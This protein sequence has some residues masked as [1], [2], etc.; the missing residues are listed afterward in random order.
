MRRQYEAPTVGASESVTEFVRGCPR[1]EMASTSTIRYRLPSVKLRKRQVPLLFLAALA[2]GAVAAAT[3]YHHRAKRAVAEYQ[4]QLLAE[5]EI[6]SV[7]QLIPKPV[8]PDQDGANLFFQAIAQLNA[9]RGVLDTNPPSGMTMVA[10][11][12]ARVGCTQPDIRSKDATNNWDEAIR[13][14]TASADSLALLEELI[15]RPNLDFK[16][17]YR[18]GFSAPLPNLAQTKR[19]AQR[20]YY[21]ALCD[22]HRGDAASATTRLRALLA[23][24]QGSADERLVISQLVRI[25]VTA[26][27]V[28]GTWELLQSPDV[29]D[30][31]LALIQYDWRR[32]EFNLSAENALAMERAM[33]QMTVE[34][35]RNSS[36]EFRQVASAYSW[37][38]AGGAPVSGD[39]LSRVGKF[40]KEAWNK[41]RLTAKEA[42]WRYSWAY[43]D[44]LR[45]LKGLQVLIEGT[46]QARTNGDFGAAL[47]D[48]ESKLQKLGFQNLE[49]NDMLPLFG[50]DVD[51]RTLFSQGVLS[52]NHYLKKVMAIET[53]R[54]LVVTATALQRYKLRHGSYPTDLAALV[55]DLLPTLPRDPADGDVLHYRANSDGN[56]LL[57]SVGGDF[58]DNGGDPQ[59][60][61]TSPASFYWQR[62]RD[63]V[64][65]QPATQKEVEDF[66]QR[67]FK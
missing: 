47:R 25:A 41:S 53:S 58:A 49:R 4:Q 6:L 44:Q 9:G 3:V 8:P 34:Q 66:Y 59:P 38:G 16:V 50:G 52:L 13:E 29:N 39:W 63:W 40:G 60:A 14:V 42:A 31:Q 28:A 46:R 64:W 20:L 7:D 33:G 62:G 26:I 21:A 67:G 35:M 54:T 30:E 19:A 57:Y 55:P 15:E 18:M 1:L 45:T 11:G 48:Q 32:L 27:G 36:E 65:P 43:T 22:L 56:F 12:K 23:L 51:F 2:L 61:N 37:P 17:D 24:A 10:P 5:G